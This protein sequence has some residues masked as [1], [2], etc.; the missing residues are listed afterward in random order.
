MDRREVDGAIKPV[1]CLDVLEV[2]NEVQSV[3]RRRPRWKETL[4]P[5]L[6]PAGL[7]APRLLRGACTWLYVGSAA[8]E[9]GRAYIWCTA[10]LA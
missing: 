9:R 3:R 6:L 4:R 5:V 1:V 10:R 2:P 7:G 8:W